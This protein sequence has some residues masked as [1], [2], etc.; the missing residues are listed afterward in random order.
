MHQLGVDRKDGVAGADQRVDTDAGGAVRVTCL[1]E[2][3]VGVCEG[4]ERDGGEFPVGGGVRYL[5]FFWG[6]WKS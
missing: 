6:K 4:I 1:G 2:G 3:D 5:V